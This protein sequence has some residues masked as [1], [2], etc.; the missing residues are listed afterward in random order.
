MPPPVSVEILDRDVAIA[1]LGGQG[2]CRV[3]FTVDALPAVLPV[4]YAVDSGVIVLSTVA[5]ARLASAADGGVLAVQVDDLDRESRTGWS[6]VVTG[7][8]DV[9]AE[10]ATWSRVRRLLDQWVP[11]RDDVVIRVPMTVVAGRRLVAETAGSR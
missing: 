7:V 3:V 11:E 8:A 9:L 2:V 5:G 6:V 10:G 1:L 4:N